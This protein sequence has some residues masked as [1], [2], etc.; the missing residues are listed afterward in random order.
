MNEM[1]MKENKKWLR[2]KKQIIH[3]CQG[4]FVLYCRDGTNKN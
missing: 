3:L 4:F 1:E 2:N